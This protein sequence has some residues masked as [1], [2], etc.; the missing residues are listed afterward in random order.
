MQD[1]IRQIKQFAA[2]RDWDRFHAPKN[3][4]MALSVEV[5]E[6]VEIFQWLNEEESYRLDPM[7]KEHLKEE[8]GDVVI[9]LTGLAA[10]FDIDPMDAARH[11]LALNRKK[12]PVTL[13]RGSRRKCNQ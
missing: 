4:A 10:K 13:A 6:L 11:K 7:Q 1:L 12:Y 2:E 8:I 9:Y 5:A 3:L